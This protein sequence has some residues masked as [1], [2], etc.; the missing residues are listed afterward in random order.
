M[1]NWSFIFIILSSSFFG[2]LLDLLPFSRSD[3]LPFTTIFWF[4]GDLLPLFWFNS[5][6]L[7]LPSLLL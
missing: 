2:P 5:D 4:T 7:P 6:L 3:L 1:L